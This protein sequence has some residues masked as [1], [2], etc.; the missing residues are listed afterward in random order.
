MKIAK[1]IAIIFFLTT[2]IGLFVSA[3]AST[4]KTIEL[5]KRNHVALVGEVDANSVEEVMNSLMARD[6][7]KPFYLYIDSP[8]GSVFA[9][10]RLID[11]LIANG[12]GVTCI[13]SNAMSMAFV[14]LQ[15]CETRLVT[16][17]SVLM[18][19]GVQTQ[20][21]GDLRRIKKDIEISEGLEKILTTISAER[22]GIS[23][24]ELMKRHNPEWWIFG[25]K[26]ALKT[27][28]ADGEA[29]VFCGSDLRGKVKKKVMTIFG[30]IEIE[31]RTC[32]L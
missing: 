24:E 20:S 18:S 31:V 25:A 8:G 2:I 29:K 19:H 14:T 5:T 7:T 23:F 32:P 6:R 12:E 30:P 27:N 3:M 1:F 9:G 10:K 16:K 21:Q 11:Y 28:T 22:I 13:A 17:A 26:E 15:V 4:P